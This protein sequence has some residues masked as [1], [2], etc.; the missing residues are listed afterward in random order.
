MATYF[1]PKSWMPLRAVDIG[2]DLGKRLFDQTWVDQW[3]TF[4]T[5]W[6]DPVADF[7]VG[8]VTALMPDVLMTLLSE[9]ILSQFGGQEVNATL[10]G[11]DLRAT[12]HTLKVRRR[13]AHFQTKTV[14]TQL[15][16]NRHPIEEL[17]VI[18]HGV[19][20]IPG[21]PTKIRAAQLDFSGVISI[22]ALLDWVNTWQPDWELSLGPDGFVLAEHRRRRIRA[23]ATAEITDN[24]LTVNVHRAHWRRVR[25]P[26]S[27]TRL[28]PI[29][30]TDLPNQLRILRAERNGDYI[31]FAADVP[32]ITGSFDLAQIRSAIVAGTTLIVF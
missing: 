13:G 16:W 32:G 9:G 6:L 17:T 18:A 21:V 20:I 10:L 7:G 23:L 1:D 8:T 24:V 29:P 19:R 11:H 4:T 26:R 25:A 28:D 12:L 5:A 31:E 22:A 14:L 3:T 15:H 2:M 30:L 27:M